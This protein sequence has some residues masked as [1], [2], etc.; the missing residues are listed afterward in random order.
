MGA[1][2]DRGR[3]GCEDDNTISIFG[4]VGE[5]AVP[6]GRGDGRWGGFQSDAS[7]AKVNVQCGVEAF[8]PRPSSRSI[9]CARMRS[10]IAS[11][12]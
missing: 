9:L 11:F 1:E 4:V 8:P 3:A 6:G 5:G 7:D 12:R 2:L 10:F